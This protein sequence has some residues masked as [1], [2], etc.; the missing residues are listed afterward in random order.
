MTGV[1]GDGAGLG[2]RLAHVLL[3]NGSAPF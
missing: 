2:R 3:Q 1:L